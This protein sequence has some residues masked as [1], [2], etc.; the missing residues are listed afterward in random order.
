MSSLLMIIQSIKDYGWFSTM[1]TILIIES[2]LLLEY[3]SLQQRLNKINTWLH[4]C[5]I[6]PKQTHDARVQFNSWSTCIRVNKWER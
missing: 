4:N 5:A 1:Y 6:L 2:D 3:V